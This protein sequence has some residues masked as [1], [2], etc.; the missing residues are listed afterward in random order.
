V[1]KPDIEG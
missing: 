1:F